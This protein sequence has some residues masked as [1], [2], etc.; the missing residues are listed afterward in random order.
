M[1]VSVLQQNTT[2]H[3]A[4][5]ELVLQDDISLLGGFCVWL[6]KIK[7]DWLSGRYVGAN[8]NT[9]E[10]EV[11]KVEIVKGDKLKFDILV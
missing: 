1:R 4:G 9:E 2:S 8:W 6:T 3:S 10:L 5:A 11:Q 7:R